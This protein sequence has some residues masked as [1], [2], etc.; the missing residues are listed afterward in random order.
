MKLDHALWCAR[1]LEG[2]A[3]ML[4]QVASADV[5]P[6][7]EAV[8]HLGKQ[9]ERLAAVHQKLQAKDGTNGDRQ[10]T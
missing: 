1:G 3:S 2:V 6:S 8:K 4:E 5:P 7:A 10:D 9:I